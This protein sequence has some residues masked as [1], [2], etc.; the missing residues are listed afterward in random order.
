MI[1]YGTST[2]YTSFGKES[3]ARLPMLLQEAIELVTKKSIPKWKTI[4]PIGISGNT[5]D[6]TDCLMPDVRYH[7]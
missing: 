6:G 7:L 3:K 4:L 5:T 2:V 1:T